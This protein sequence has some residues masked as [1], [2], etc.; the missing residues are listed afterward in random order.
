MKEIMGCD[1]LW[2]AYTVSLRMLRKASDPVDW[3][4]VLISEFGVSGYCSV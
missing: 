3:L 1:L 4:N 2:Y